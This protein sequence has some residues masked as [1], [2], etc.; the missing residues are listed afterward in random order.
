M[1]ATAE[2]LRSVRARITELDNE[3]ESKKEG[4][5]TVLAEAR[6]KAGGDM[7]KLLA[8][9]PD[10]AS[11]VSEQG[12]D[13][14]GLKEQRLTAGNLV[15]T[16]L[17]QAQPSTPSF[18][19][20]SGRS[21]AAA[22]L[23]DAGYAR[24]TA[25][26]LYGQGSIGDLPDVDVL[27]RDML[28]SRLK[29]GRPMFEAAATADI[30]D[31]IPLDQRLYPPVDI[32]RRQ[33][34]LIDLLTVGATN[35]ESVVY[36]R[37]T[38]RTAAAAET[39]LGT[40]YSEA[41]FDFVKVTANVESIGHF[42]TAYR[43]NIADAA[44]FE[45]IVENQLQEDVMLRL[46]Q[47]LLTG[48]GSG[49]NLTGILHT[50]G[51]NSV[52]RDVTTPERR[53]A[54]LHRGITAIRVAAFREPDAILLHPNDY[55]DM[56]LQEINLA[57]TSGAASMFAANLR[58]GTPASVWGLPIVVSTVASEGTGLVGYFKDA[59]LWVRS[60]VAVRLSDSHSD[61]FT[62]RQVAILAEMRGAFSVQ[63]PSAFCEVDLL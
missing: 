59:T 45:T 15:Q 43:E 51:I 26:F 63:R 24:M 21:V 18:E 13:L 4:F 57:N 48:D 50:S 60:G 6:E 5:E 16:L 2:D 56:L 53:V 49:S 46:E 29:S 35:V 44:Q 32:R 40:A 30:S 39:A 17:S 12:K 3:I 22:I 58:D 36:A 34:R 54:T 7:G 55:Q 19:R 41:S 38:V 9:H 8:E 31:G 62:K 25:D 23:G 28:V 1:P 33:L 42:T 61:Y 52:F 27:D 11:A 14:D 37:Q 20:K 10:L 47:Q